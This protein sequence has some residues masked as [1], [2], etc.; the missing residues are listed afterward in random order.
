MFEIFIGIVGV[1]SLTLSF[2]LLLISTTANIKENLW[3]FGVLRAIGLTMEQSKRVFMYEAFAVIFGALLLGTLVGIA[4][5][6]TLTAQF[7]LFIELPFKLSF[8]TYLFLAMVTMS[9]VTTFFA[10]WIPV[11]EVNGRRIA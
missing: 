7:Y 2:F 9:L 11:K 3:E 5:A 4:V 8:P 6:V 1:I 10:V